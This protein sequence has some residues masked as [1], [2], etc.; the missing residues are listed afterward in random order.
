MPENNESAGTP[1]GDQGA[2]TNESDNGATGADKTSELQAQLDG[3]QKRI[4]QLN[5]EAK[6]HRLDA[7]THKTR[8][9]DAEKR[10]ADLEQQISDITSKLQDAEDQKS[11]ASLA[12]LRMRVGRKHGLPDELVDRL[13]GNDE[14]AIEEDAQR[15]AAVARTDGT[16]NPL[17]AGHG[18]AASN[19]S[20]DAMTPAQRMSRAYANKQNTA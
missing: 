19:P 15:L 6:T 3:A 4:H 11:A 5:E 14:A 10:L 13:Q 12:V 16:R 20:G 1:N 2:G 18:S 7:G 8:A 9:D 17:G